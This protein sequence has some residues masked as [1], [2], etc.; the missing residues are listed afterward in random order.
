MNSEMTFCNRFKTLFL[1]Q[2]LIACTLVLTQSRVLAGQDCG[3]RAAPTPQA[4]AKGLALGERLRDQLEAGGASAALVGRIGLNL[5]EFGQRYTH[6]GMAVRDHVRK[7]WLV[8]HL[9]NPCG[10]SES[11]I[12]VQPLERFYE[13]DLFDYEGLVITPSYVHQAALRS[14]FMN[15]AT[16]RLLHTSAYN[17]I[18]HPFNTRFQNSNQWILEMTALALEGKGSIRD[19]AAAQ[20]W[21][22]ARGFE[23]GNIRIPN[24]RRSA[25]RLFSAHVSFADHTQEEYE[26]QQYFVVT[27]DAI[28]RFL[29]AQDRDQKQ[30]TV[31]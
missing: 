21:L 5:S 22:K 10:K 15:P 2:V 26:K 14:A 6:M 29:A 7:R 1:A 17:L 20:N 18:A 11:E 12:L 4:L 24:V 30:I 13:V 28:A 23:P 27:V 31:R 25:A 19:R 3:E 16:A 8:M 9:F